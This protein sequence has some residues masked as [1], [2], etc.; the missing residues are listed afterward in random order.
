MYRVIK[1][2]VSDLKSEMHDKYA[3]QNQREIV[4]QCGPTINFCC[5]LAFFQ[6]KNISI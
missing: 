6:E 5:T 4:E 2:A 1:T 3:V